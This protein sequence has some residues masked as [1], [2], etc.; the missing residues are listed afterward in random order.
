MGVRPENLD[1]KGP[2][3]GS[4]VGMDGLASRASDVAEGA[5]SGCGIRSSSCGIGFDGRGNDIRRIMGV[6][7]LQG[8]TE[9]G[10]GSDAQNIVWF[11]LSISREWNGSSAASEPL[12]RGSRSTVRAREPSR[13]TKLTGVS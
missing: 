13:Q 10:L 7:G 8:N 9:K 2:Q 12:K 1:A 11:E 3:S 6:Q 4:D 5:L